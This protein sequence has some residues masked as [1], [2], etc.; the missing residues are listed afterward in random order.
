MASR[1]QVEGVEILVTRNGYVVRVSGRET[2]HGS[3]INGAY[4]FSSLAEFGAW[5]DKRLAKPDDVE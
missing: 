4:V 3:S 1:N 5:L 2:L